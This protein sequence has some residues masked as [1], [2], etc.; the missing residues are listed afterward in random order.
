VQAAG[1]L[2]GT[3]IAPASSTKM[4]N[5]TG[6]VLGFENRCSSAYPTLP[7]AATG[8][9]DYGFLGFIAMPLPFRATARGSYRCRPRR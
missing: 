6:T 2:E 9:N 4:P 1:N 5:V 7:R 3:R 8:V